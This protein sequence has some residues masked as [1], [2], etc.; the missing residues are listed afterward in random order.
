MAL[1]SRRV[2]LD[3]A[4]IAAFG[5]TPVVIIATNVGFQAHAVAIDNYSAYYL[6]IKDALSFIPPF[7]GGA[8]RILFHTTDQAYAE[9]ES[10][11]G[12][13]QTPGDPSYFVDFTWTDA[14]APFNAG[15]SIAGVTNNVLLNVL[16]DFRLEF[17]STIVTLTSFPLPLPATPMPGRTSLMLQAPYSNSGII[18]VG[19]SNVTADQAPTGGVQIYPGQSM[20]IEAGFGA[21][22]YG[23]Q[24][25]LIG[26]QQIIVLEGK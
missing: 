22:P 11:F 6:Y 25:P 26:P 10:P 24:D 21:V 16:D 9:L 12:D 3:T 5:P 7:W 19:G 2:P 1:F 20:P 14:A 15:G 13:P 4:A 18:Y 17:L 23:I 8:V